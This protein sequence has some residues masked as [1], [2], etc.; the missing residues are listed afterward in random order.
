VST[1]ARTKH[2]AFARTPTD[3]NKFLGTAGR[4]GM[5][6]RIIDNVQLHYGK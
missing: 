1:F 5:L 3:A 6:T 4:K 2:S